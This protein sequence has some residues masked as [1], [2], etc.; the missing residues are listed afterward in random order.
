MIFFLDIIKNIISR[1]ED[2]EIELK[3]ANLDEIAISGHTEGKRFLPW[4]MFD[5]SRYTKR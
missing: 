1:L 3:S 5:K 2:M 4:Q